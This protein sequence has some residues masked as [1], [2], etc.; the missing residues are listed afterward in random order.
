MKRFRF[1]LE[2]LLSLRR[3]KEREWELKLADITGQCLKIKNNI[4]IC[5]NNISRHLD[6]RATL[7]QHI[8][9]ADLQANELFIHKMHQ[10]INR[11]EKELVAKQAKQRKVQQEYLKHSQKRKVLEKL[12]EKREAEYYKEQKLYEQKE[13]DDIVLGQKTRD[14]IAF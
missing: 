2:R 11:L 3:H 5:L 1:R 4:T 13:I 8:D 7:T 14:K 9:L 10:D 6:I 12:K